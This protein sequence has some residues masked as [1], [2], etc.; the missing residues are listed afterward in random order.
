MPRAGRRFERRIRPTE[1]TDIIP[2]VT[3]P[4]RG[5]EAAT[6]EIPVVAD[7]E[8]TGEIPP[9]PDIDPDDDDEIDDVAHDLE[10][11]AD[12]VH[13]TVEY[14]DRFSELREQAVRVSSF[15]WH[16]LVRLSAA[17]LAWLV[18]ETR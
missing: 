9:V 4:L 5:D 7:A 16:H 1:R 3:D 10:A 14:A 17:L 13:E 11:G 12:D 15:L 6:G 2:A 18:R 8:V